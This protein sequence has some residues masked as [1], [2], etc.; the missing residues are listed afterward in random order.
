MCENN[1]IS[2]SLFRGIDPEKDQSYFLSALRPDQLEKALFPIGHLHK[3]E[4]RE[5][6]KKI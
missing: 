5:L 3:S 2:P 1:A 4:V 6:A